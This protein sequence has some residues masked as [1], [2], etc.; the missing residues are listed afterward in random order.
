LCT[1][2]SFLHMQ[3]PEMMSVCLLK[4]W[5]FGFIARFSRLC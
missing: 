5:R 3:L 2:G 1:D 4:F